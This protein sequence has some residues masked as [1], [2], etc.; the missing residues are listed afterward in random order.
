MLSDLSPYGWGGMLLVLFL[1]TGLSFYGMVGYHQRRF[2]WTGLPGL[3]LMLAVESCWQPV[4]SGLHSP[5]WCQSVSVWL[6]VVLT[7][8]LCMG[9]TVMLLHQHR[10]Q[11]ST[12]SRNS[13]KEAIDKLPTGLCFAKADGSVILSNHKMNDL[14]FRLTGQELQDVNA[15][16]VALQ[17]G[18][19]LTEVEA[20]GSM[21]FCLPEG[22]VWSF[23]ETTLDNGLIQR[24]AATPPGFMPWQNPCRSRMSS[25][26]P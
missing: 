20:L 9:L 15:F 23:T 26:L 11:Q 13:I 14:S 16:W 24:T 12:I 8:C 18:R 19:V 21:N 3:V 5:A 25:W 10:M 1:T 2:L 17:T 7:V 22:T 4:R 6:P